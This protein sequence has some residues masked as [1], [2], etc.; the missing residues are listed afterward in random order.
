MSPWTVSPCFQPASVWGG[1][2]PSGRWY[3]S[4]MPPLQHHN[5]ACYH[6]SPLQ[7]GRQIRLS[8]AA[9]FQ[10]LQPSW[11]TS[12]HLWRCGSP[13][14]AGHVLPVAS[15]LRNQ[16]PEASAVPSQRNHRLSMPS[17]TW[18]FL[19]AHGSWMTWAVPLRGLLGPLRLAATVSTSPLIWHVQPSVWLW[20]AFRVL[21]IPFSSG[22]DRLHLCGVCARQWISAMPSQ[23]P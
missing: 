3:N 23:P 20:S 14:S 10:P 13:L 12:A 5:S 4:R 8:T 9:Q 21:P 1:S 15:A 17:Q 18:L 7:Y 16:V 2:P 6:R 19:A 11:Q 22:Q